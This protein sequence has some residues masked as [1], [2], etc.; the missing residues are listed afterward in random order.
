[1]KSVENRTYRVSGLLIHISRRSIEHNG[2]ERYVRPKTFDLLIYLLNARDRLVAKEELLS[3]IWEDATV[4]EN[5]LAQCIAELRRVLG[6]DSR[7]PRFLR[8]VP[9]SGYQFIAPVEEVATAVPAPPAESAATALPAPLAE[10]GEAPA[11][12]PR[13]T[14]EKEHSRSIVRLAAIGLALIVACGVLVSARLFHPSE[15]GAIPLTAGKGRVVVWLFDNQSD[16]PDLEWL[17]EGL[18]QRVMTNL[19]R[20]SKLA[21]IG[22]QHWHGRSDIPSGLDSA[23]R[24][25]KHRSA[26]RLILGSFVRLGRRIRISVRLHDSKGAAI[27]FESA[28]AVAPEEILEQVD[29]LSAKLASHL[30]APLLADATERELL[31][32]NLE[33]YRRYSLAMQKANA[34]HTREAIELLEQAI[35]LDPS[36]AMAH[37]RMGYIYTV[38]AG[39]PRKGAPYLE[40]AFEFS[41]GLT[42]KDRQYISAWYALAI[43]DYTGAIR[44]F[45]AI[46]KRYPEEMEAWARLGRLLGGEGQYDEAIAV[47]KQGLK[48][49]PDV[50]DIYNALGY[51]YSQ[52]GRHSDAAAMAKR[53]VELAPA[54]PNAY[55]SLGLAYDW[56]GR[57]SEAEQA[58]RRALELKPDFEPA[59]IHR[60]ALFFHTGRYRE[61]LRDCRKYVEIAP[62]EIE[63]GRGYGCLATIY[64]HMGDL[65][66]AEETARAAVQSRPDQS[67]ILRLVLLRRGRPSRELPPVQGV[68]VSAR[69][70]RLPRRS[71]HY[72][73]GE[74][75]FLLNRTDEALQHF[76]EALR[77]RP[78]WGEIDWHED[79]LANALLRLGRIQEAIQEYQRVLGMYPNDGILHYWLGIAFRQRG[80]IDQANQHFT[81]FLTLWNDAD[82]D[83]PYVVEAKRFLAENGRQLARR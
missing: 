63:L 6:D 47:L 42:E 80:D 3:H 16:N 51:I 40:K 68:N 54:E 23:L 21:I 7:N 72:F 18:A 22:N 36:F 17:R 34:Y 50:H 13:P 30:G 49:E 32:R 75:A 74:A 25:A 56:S 9:K 29:L 64:L 37:A 8:T 66:H 4:T 46:V 73:S 12:P 33:A 70:A 39:R 69:G 61:A 48:V 10:S 43:E 19:S 82:A 11:V 55:D 60:A 35:A 1:M 53:Y 2:I 44:E 45:R 38:T 26:E 5:S 77:H 28:T 20:S 41:H 31:T 71:A 65:L 79:C 57:Y 76:R 78:G 27:A 81:R 58:F 52:L 15:R 24:F 62:S 67:G 59:L 14:R 83:I